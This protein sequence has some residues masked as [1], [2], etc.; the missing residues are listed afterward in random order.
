MSRSTFSFVREFSPAPESEFL[1]D[2]HYL[3]CVSSGALRLESEGRSWSL[4]PARA[5]L[6][7]AGHPIAVTIPQPVTTASVLFDV[8]FAPLPPVPLAVFDLS[9]LARTLVDECGQW[10]E[11][12]EQLSPYAG[13]MFRALAES[14]WQLARQP[15]PAFMPTGRSSELRRA[16]SLT[17]DRIAENVRFDE[18]A[19][20]VGMAPRSLARRFEEEIGMT[21]QASLRRL[22][23]LRAIEL[24]AETNAPVTEVAFGVGYSS[25]SAFNAAFREFIG[26]TPTAYR[27]SFVS[28]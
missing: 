27:R 26:Q 9:Q 19:A 20:E 5:A 7:R 10:G 24:L 22:R 23:V 12:D 6:I 28:S 25:L 17:S 13:A 18:I 14:V 21:W 11:S 8:R 2:R 3:L 16:I 4:P 1:V 15:S